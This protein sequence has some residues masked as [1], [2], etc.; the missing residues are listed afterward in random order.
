MTL[1][2]QFFNFQPITARLFPIA[3]PFPV[4]SILTIL[5]DKQLLKSFENINILIKVKLFCWEKNFFQKSF[6]LEK[7]CHLKETKFFGEK[8]FFVEKKCFLEKKLFFGK[9]LFL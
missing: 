4:R 7:D 8:R 5:L 3:T 2:Q 6:H 9:N 1:F